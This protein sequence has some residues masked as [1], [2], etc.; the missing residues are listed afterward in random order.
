MWDRSLSF[1]LLV[2]LAGAVSAS[3]PD[4]LLEPCL[5]DVSSS[6]AFPSQE[7]EDQIRAYLEWRSDDPTYLFRVFGVEVAAPDP[8][9]ISQAE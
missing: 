1:A 8:G 9:I 4:L 7:M 2:F 6:G 3:D 5:N